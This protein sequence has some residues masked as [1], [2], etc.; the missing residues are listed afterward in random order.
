[1]RLQALAAGAAVS[2]GVSRR[3]IG[4]ASDGSRKAAKPA[5]CTAHAVAQNGVPTST[6]GKA[7]AA[8]PADQGGAASAADAALHSGAAAVRHA[9]GNLAAALEAAI[10]SHKRGDLYEGEGDGAADGAIGGGGGGSG[11]GEGKK[12]QR[13]GAIGGRLRKKLARQR[14]ADKA[15]KL[16]TK[17]SE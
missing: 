12:R 17:H 6:S 16:I 5:A 8:L 3:P 4:A 1:M 9:T 2:R 10:G 7:A 13:S 14:A 11:D 15:Q